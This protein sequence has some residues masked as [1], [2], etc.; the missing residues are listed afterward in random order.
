LKRVAEIN[1]TDN[2]VVFMAFYSLILQQP[3]FYWDGNFSLCKDGMNAS[4]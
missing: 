3:N 4:M 2:T 1:T